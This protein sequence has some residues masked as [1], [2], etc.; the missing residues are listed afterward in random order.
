[1]YTNK[2][3]AGF[4]LALSTH[5]PVLAATPTDWVTTIDYARYGSSGTITFNDWGYVGPNNVGANDFEVTSPI[6]GVTGFD[7]SRIGQE[8]NVLTLDPDWSTPDPA[9]TSNMTEFGA[10]PRYNTS[11]DAQVNF[12]WWTYTTVGGS[13]FDNMQI[14]KAGNYFV[15]KENMNFQFYDTF[16][17]HDTTGAPDNET[18]IDTNINFKPYASSDATGW[19]GST[20]NSDPNGLGVM[21]GQVQFDLSMDVYMGDGEQ[22]LAG[23]ITQIIPDFVMRS[24]GS[25]VV[26]IDR[27]QHFVGSAVMNNN[28]PEISPLDANGEVTDAAVD[29]AYQNLVSFLGAGVIPKGVWVKGSSYTS[30]GVKN[31]NADGTWAYTIVDDAANALCDPN[32]LAATPSPEAGAVCHGNFF[33]GYAFLMRA[34]GQRTLTYI[35]PTGHSDYVSTVP[36]PA[37]A[38]LLGSGLLALGGAYRRRVC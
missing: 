20:L 22:S 17:Y 3:V 5:G 13:T 38:W 2:A 6:T 12:F 27:N 29:P 8:Q 31:L 37:A 30:P 19:C 21:A 35:N 33:A 32:N 24:Y 16:S 11:Q 7:A 18:V 34:D 28:N 14:D 4:V 26:D 23:G 9:I 15:A 36:V 10:V 25:Y 1:M